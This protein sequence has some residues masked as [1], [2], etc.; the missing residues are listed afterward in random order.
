MRCR[1]EELGEHIDSADVL[2][3]LI[4]RLDAAALARATRVRL[5]IQF[6]V[7]LESVDVEEVS[8]YHFQGCS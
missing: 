2:V 8:T 7:G 6:G 1:K 5:I 4:A 3:P